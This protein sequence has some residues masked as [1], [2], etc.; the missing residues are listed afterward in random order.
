MGLP[1]LVVA[2][3]EAAREREATKEPEVTVAAPTPLRSVPALPPDDDDATTIV[4]PPSSD[5]TPPGP[6]TG[7]RHRDGTEPTREIDWP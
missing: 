7:R 5:T 1:R 3:Q 2:E 6:R 4:D